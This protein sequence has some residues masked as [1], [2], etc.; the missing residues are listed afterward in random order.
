MNTD[1]LYTDSYRREAPRDTVEPGELTMTNELTPTAKVRRGYGTRYEIAATHPDGRRI[2]VGFTARKSRHGLLVIMRRRGAYL[3]EALMIG[4][5]DII[6]FHTK[7]RVHARVAG[8]S[9]GFTGRTELQCQQEAFR[10]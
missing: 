1:D 4:E 10:K 6:T 8:W 5:A 9:V 2:V 3:I 7:P